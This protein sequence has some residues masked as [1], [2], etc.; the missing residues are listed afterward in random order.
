MSEV[1]VTIH[2][3]QLRSLGCG[4][5]MNMPRS[6]ASEWVVEDAES[7]GGLKA[8]KSALDGIPIDLWFLRSIYQETFEVDE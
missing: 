6:I 5:A 3:N 1:K 7:R 2:R 8:R 4:G